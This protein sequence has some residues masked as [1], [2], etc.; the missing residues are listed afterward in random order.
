MNAAAQTYWFGHLGEADAYNDWIFDELVPH[1]GPRV[2]EVGCGNGNFSRRIA[3]QAKAL[4]AVDIEPAFIEQTRQRTAD[5]ANVTVEEADV[6]TM[7]WPSKFD[8]AVM[9]DV[10]EH[11]EDDVAMLR[12]LARALEPDGRLVVKVPAIASIYN[13]LDRAVGHYR[14][15]SRKHLNE[16]VAA[17]GFE[18]QQM[19][20]FNLL[21]VAG[22]W[23]NGSV[24]RRS[25]PP[26][27][28]ISH[29]NTLVPVL[30]KLEAALRPSIGAS[31]FVVARP[32]AG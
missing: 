4:L 27:H 6:T 16:V 5:L 21:G 9:L 19:W 17:S 14:R 28:H 8:T 2:L 18:V 10:L 31:L 29:F 25:V 11:I 30:R 32:A 12:S 23:L 7:K 15:Y 13:N 26:S 24:L 22:W 20:G 3:L 1:L